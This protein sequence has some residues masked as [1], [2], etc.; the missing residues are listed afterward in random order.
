MNLGDDVKIPIVKAP[1]NEEEDKTKIN[2]ITGGIQLKNGNI[3][4][5]SYEKTIT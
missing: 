3:L 1:L 4:L 5:I 2:L